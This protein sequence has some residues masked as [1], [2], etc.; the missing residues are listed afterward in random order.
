MK[1]PFDLS[2]SKVVVAGAGGLIG[3]AVCRSVLSAGGE[4]IGIDRDLKSLPSHSDNKISGLMG[5]LT[6]EGSLRSVFQQLKGDGNWSF[7]HA[8]YPRTTDWGKKSFLETDFEHFD[9]NLRLQLGSTF[10]FVKEAVQFLQTRGGGS[11]I[12]FS[13]IYGLAGPRMDLYEGTSL[14]NPVPYAATKGGVIA[15]SRYVATVFGKQG[16]RSNVVSPGGV[17]DAQPES[18]VTAY[19]KQTPLGRMAE[20]Q[21]IGDATAFLCS[22]AA[23][24]I[25]GT[26]LVVDGGFTA[27]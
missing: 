16:I 22:P 7:V 18:F 13:S 1:N 11:I 25:S 8:A 20:P 27:W 4:V 6:D 19:S 2:E 17:K 12:T 23:R 15:L 9:Q 10:L 14:T 5:D 3:Q 24:Y 26:N 21:E